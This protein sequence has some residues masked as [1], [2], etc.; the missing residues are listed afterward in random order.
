M[1]DSEKYDKYINPSHSDRFSQT[2]LY[3]KYGVVHFVI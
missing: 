3:N 2:Y 1:K